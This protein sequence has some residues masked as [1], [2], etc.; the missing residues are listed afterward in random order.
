MYKDQ[1]FYGDQRLRSK[2]VEIFNAVLLDNL[3]N[4]ITW[5]EK[6]YKDLLF[7]ENEVMESKQSVHVRPKHYKHNFDKKPDEPLLF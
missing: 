4:V 7:Y 3:T 5:P 6:W 2:L 1:P